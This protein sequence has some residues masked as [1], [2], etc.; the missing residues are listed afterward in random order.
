MTWVLI[1]PAGEHHHGSYWGLRD[2]A[3]ELFAMVRRWNPDGTELA[4]KIAKG[5]VMAPAIMFEGITAWA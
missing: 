5:W 3:E 1:S 2:T 4:P